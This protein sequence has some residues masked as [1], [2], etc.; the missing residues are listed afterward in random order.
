M[1][2]WTS[3]AVLAA[4][5]F[6]G[7]CT[8][9]TGP[10]QGTPALASLAVAGRAAGV[11]EHILWQS[12]TAPPLEAYELS[13]WAVRGRK[14]SIRIDYAEAQSPDQDHTKNGKFLRLD[15]PADAL[16]SYP[17]G[18]PFEDGDAVL[19]SISVDPS[20]FLVQLEPSGLVFDPASPARLQ[21]WYGN[22]DADLNR[23]GEVD[24]T[25]EAIGRDWLRMWYQAGPGAPW[26]AWDAVHTKAEKRFMAD[27]IH[28]S[29][30]AV[31]W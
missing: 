27:L 25:D 4:A 30:Y 7:A 17:D 9:A 19:V 21:I 8:D 13:F 12:V 16:L 18:T 14:A 31:S 2:R 28:F 5:L 20:R 29:G 23:D 24:E 11:E 10:P 22:A 3:I 15:I 1:G 26:S 6:C